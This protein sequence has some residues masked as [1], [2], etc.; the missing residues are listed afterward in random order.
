MANLYESVLA[1]SLQPFFHDRA[2]NYETLR[3]KHVQIVWLEQ[4]FFSS[5]TTLEG[6]PIQVLSP[7]IWNAEAGPDF[8]KAHLKIGDKDLRGDVELHLTDDKWN[9]H[10]HNQDMRYDNVILHVSMWRANEFKSLRTS[11]GR[12]I[13]QC[14]LEDFLNIPLHKITQLI[15]L[16]LYPYEQF[17]G[18]GKCAE[19]IFQKIS[20]EKVRRFF[21]SAAHWRLKQKYVHICSE[22]ECVSTRF[23][24]GLAGVLGYKNNKAAFVHIF[25]WLQQ[26]KEESI[27]FLLSLALGVSGFFEVHFQKLW[28]ESAFYQQLF[29][30]FQSHVN[31][32]KFVLQ[33]SQI[34]PANHPVRRLAL[35][36]YLIKSSFTQGLENRLLLLWQ[37][38]W[39]TCDDTKDYIKLY[40]LMVKTFPSFEGTYWNE[41]YTFEVKLQPKMAFLGDELKGKMILNVLCPFLYQAVLNRDDPAEINAFENFY[42]GLPSFSSRKNKYLMHRFFGNTHLSKN[43]KKGEIEQGAHQLHRDFCLHYEASCQ[44][45]PFIESYQAQMLQLL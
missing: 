13:Y 6:L 19:E 22:N 11:S 32:P 4:K 43:M 41:H 5:L 12:H 37:R 39:K 26:Y 2:E 17:V 31:L 34:R 29:E 16:D 42:S 21:Q 38:H 8:L 1:A 33:L 24:S 14:Y 27:D 35:L 7:G 10:G 36:T 3:E 45:C 44:G 25:L 18:N 23:T 20:E 40:Q 30:K 28:K 9:Q 15:D